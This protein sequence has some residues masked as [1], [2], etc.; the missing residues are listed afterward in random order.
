MA[1]SQRLQ[2]KLAQKLILTP[3]LQQAIK[4]LPMSTL[5]LAD[6]LTQEVVENPLLE[7]IPTEDLQAT[8]AQ[9][10][11][12]KEQEAPKPEA[13]NDSAV[14]ATPSSPPAAPTAS[15]F[16]LKAPEA[17]GSYKLTDR[18]DSGR[19]SDGI[20]HTY[21][22][23]T[24]ESWT[25]TFYK[26]ERANLG[27]DPDQLLDAQLQVFAQILEYQRLQGAFESRTAVLF[28]AENRPHDLE[29]LIA[30]PDDPHD[31]SSS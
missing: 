17:F 11:T 28:R 30:E 16:A 31:F 9:P 24:G 7:E 21:T 2:T 14:G 4:L 5:E 29:L 27:Q 6:L 13:K 15:V 19:P 10:A 22:S 12:E 18:K 3:S 8:D 26:L 20:S 23:P 1:I 25:V